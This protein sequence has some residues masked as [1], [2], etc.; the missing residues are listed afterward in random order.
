VIDLGNLFVPIREV[1]DIG[2][3]KL[4]FLEPIRNMAN[5]LVTRL[6]QLESDVL[7]VVLGGDHSLSLGTVAATAKRYGDVAL[8]WIDA[9]PDFNTSATTLTG[10]IHG[11]VLAALAGLGDPGLTSIGGITPK[12]R[13]DRIAVVGARDFDPEERLLLADQKVNIFTMSD[14]QRHG[15]V[16]VMADAVSS[17]TQAG[18]PLHVSF[19][20]DVVDPQ[21]A[22]GTG[23]PVIGGLTSR[24]AFAIARLIVEHSDFVALDFVEV[25][26]LF[27]NH[28]QTGLLAGDLILQLFKGG[29]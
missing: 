6:E 29:D 23:A 10:N 9:H 20:I 25:D 21:F 16:H 26:P 5:E 3:P 11:Q 14:I 28:N 24:E 12:V 7:P 27:D 15:I 19:D 22:P 1:L 8:L 17:I 13:P 18:V 2:D 4:R